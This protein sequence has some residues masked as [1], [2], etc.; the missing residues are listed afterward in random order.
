MISELGSPV[1]CAVNGMALGGGMEIALAC[2]IRIADANAEFGLT[3]VQ[4]GVLP[5][6]GGTQRLSKLIAPGKAK[7]MIFTSKRINA[8]EALRI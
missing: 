8:E 3:E 4:L 6:G 5:G 1:I 7:E 2:N